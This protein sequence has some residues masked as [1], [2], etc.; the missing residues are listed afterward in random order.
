MFRKHLFYPLN[1][2]GR[3]LLSVKE[4]ALLHISCYLQQIASAKIMLSI[5]FPKKVL[6]IRLTLRNLSQ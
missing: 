4:Q 3:L 2:Q 1:Y 5:D 6:L